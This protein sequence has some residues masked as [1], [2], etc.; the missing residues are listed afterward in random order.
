[1]T[2][3]D[4]LSDVAPEIIESDASET[5]GTEAIDADDISQSEWTLLEEEELIYFYENHPDLW[6]HK[7]ENYKSQ[8]RGQIVDDLIEMLDSK[9]TSKYIP[10]SILLNNILKQLFQIFCRK[11]NYCKI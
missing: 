5:Y 3:L 8:Q 1:M 4:K 10:P 9:F 6:D 11:R 7:R 2:F